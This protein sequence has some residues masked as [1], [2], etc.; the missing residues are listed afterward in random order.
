MTYY[1]YHLYVLDLTRNGPMETSSTQFELS[2][3]VSG[4]N[5]ISQ[6]C[7]QMSVNTGTQ[8]KQQTETGK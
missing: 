1:L 3:E 5:V 2:T 4:Q 6:I 7:Q 8:H